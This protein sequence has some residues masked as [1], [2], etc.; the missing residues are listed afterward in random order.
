MIEFV[1]EVLRL[2]SASVDLATANFTLNE[3]S[4]AFPVVV[5]CN[6]NGSLLTVTTEDDGTN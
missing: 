4:T 3:L 1:N 6:L 2:G 5:K